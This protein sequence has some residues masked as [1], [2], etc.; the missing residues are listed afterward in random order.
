MVSGRIL[1][2]VIGQ[3]RKAAFPY[4]EQHE[5]VNVAIEAPHRIAAPLGAVLTTLASE[6]H[7]RT[8]GLGLGA[9]ELSPEVVRQP[10]TDNPRATKYEAQRL[11]ESFAQ[12]EDAGSRRT[13][14][15]RALAPLVRGVLAARV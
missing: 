3:A 10:L 11:G 5:P 13:E 15:T 2:A 12:L 6:L 1:Y 7:E 4:I 14:D 8:K 9:R